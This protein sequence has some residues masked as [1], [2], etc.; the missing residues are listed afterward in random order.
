MVQG[1]VLIDQTRRGKA[2]KY[3]QMGHVEIP[4]GIHM[5]LKIIVF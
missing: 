4:Q 1:S 5:V 3:G 2:K